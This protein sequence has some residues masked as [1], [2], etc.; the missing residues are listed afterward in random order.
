MKKTLKDYLAYCETRGLKPRL[1]RAV[2]GQHG[3]WDDWQESAP[4]IAR[5]GIEGGFFGFVY[6]AE[7]TE[8]A[9]RNRG[10]IA[11]YADSMA[12]DMGESATKMIQ[13][14]P[15]LGSDYSEAE[16]GRCLYG[17]GDDTQILNAL[18][19]FAAETCASEY[20][21]WLYEARED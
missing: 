4:D 20:V 21:N 17:R 6:F 12:A 2:I 9:R 1:A 11:D 15:C 14:F 18:A 8:F 19:W 3:T 7:T 10:L 5:H 16:I 13:G